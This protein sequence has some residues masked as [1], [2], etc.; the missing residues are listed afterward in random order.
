MGLSVTGALGLD[1]TEIGSSETTNAKI[2]QTQEQTQTSKESGSIAQEV[3]SLDDETLGGLQNLVQSLMEGNFSGEAI[4]G[5]AKE[6]AQFISD[7]AQA[8]GGEQKDQNTAIVNEARRKGESQLAKIQQELAK[9]SGG[10]TANTLVASATGE[11]AVGLESQLA[12]IQ[13]KLGI[14]TRRAETEELN[15][16][17][18]SLLGS[19]QSGQQNLV[20][21]LNTLKGS[22]VSSLQESDKTSQTDLSSILEQLTESTTIGSSVEHSRSLDLGVVSGNK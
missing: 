2:N 9:Q 8:G 15:Q 3:S 13:A 18:S 14:E 10:S 4:A 22:Q 11:A 7:R 21:L 16:A 1:K 20:S 19:E 12:D 5:S 6:L 17:F